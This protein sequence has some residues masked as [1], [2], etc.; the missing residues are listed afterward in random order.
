MGS[1]MKVLFIIGSVR[2]GR[3]AAYVSKWVIGRL[4]QDSDIELDVADLKEVN[5]PFFNEAV[6]PDTPNVRFKNDVG[7][8]WAKRVDKADA[9]VMLTPEYN[10]GT[11]AVLKNAI[12]WVYW[13]WLGKPVGFISYGG[14]VAGAR[15]VEQLRQNIV[16]VKLFSIAT[17]VHIPAVSKAFDENGEPKEPRLN[18]SLANVVKELKELQRRLAT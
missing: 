1:Y 4:K 5:L 15:A 14:M 8:T 3:A 2:E 12:D 9:Y 16:N 6:T 11:S 18:D 13:G 17:S 7:N 10:H